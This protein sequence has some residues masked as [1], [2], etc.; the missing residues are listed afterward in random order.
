M[1]KENILAEI[2]RLETRIWLINMA[3]HLTNEDW[4]E[5]AHAKREIRE[6]KAMLETL[7]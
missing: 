3:D 4:T 7:G 5:I 6:L 2:D 1:K